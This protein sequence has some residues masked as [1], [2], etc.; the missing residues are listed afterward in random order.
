[1]N[2]LKA[3]MT[4]ACI[5]AT[6]GLAPAAPAATPEAAQSG[7][8]VVASATVTATVTGIDQ[9]TREVSVK[10]D[11]GRELSFVAGDNVQ[12]LAQVKVGDVIAVQYTEALAYEVKK[13]G[14]A[15][16]PVTAVAGQAAAPGSKPAGAIAQQTTATVLITAIDTKAPSI[17]IKGASGKTK[18]IK[19]LHPERL[20]GVK[21]GDTVQITYTEALAISV[22]KAQKK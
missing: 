5:A 21:V 15:M 7:Q 22:E 4:A 20:E 1:M 2:R 9:K 19:V 6:L 8:A 16:A 14:Q 3:T 10:T 11:D 13:G 12:N 17:T 18:T